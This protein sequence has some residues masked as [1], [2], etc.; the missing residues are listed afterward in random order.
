MRLRSLPVAIISCVIVCAAT[1]S[2]HAQQHDE[3]PD[4]L[5]PLLI[6]LMQSEHDEFYVAYTR[7]GERLQRDLYS[8]ADKVFLTRAL[9][10]RADRSPGL[11]PEIITLLGQIESSEALPALFRYV[12]EDDMATRLHAVQ[13]LGW[14]GDPHATQALEKVP[15]SDNTQLEWMLDYAMKAIAVKQDIRQS[16]SAPRSRPDARFEIISRTLLEEPNWLVRADIAR[17]L[18]SWPDERVWALLFDAHTRWDAP[19]P[20]TEHLRTV[21]TDRY[22]YNPKG[23]MRVLRERGTSDRVFGLRAI[24]YDAAPS[25][26]SD[27]ME[28]AETDP[29]EEVRVHA[30]QALGNLLRR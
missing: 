13:A 8:A 6:M 29:E 26:L 18:C 14:I 5:R 9:V 25:H 17:F 20:Y 12:R 7:V 15:S 11:K 4:Y 21:M 16:T 24:E 1:G 19:Q 2:I 23:F 30:V 3:P 10:Y 27:L 28:L 22:R